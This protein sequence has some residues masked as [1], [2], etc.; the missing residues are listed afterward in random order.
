M[1][2]PPP[3]LSGVRVIDLAEGFAGSYCAQLLGDLGATVIKVE[4]PQGDPARRTGPRYPGA[5]RSATSALFVAF[6]RGKQSVCLDL[7]SDEG[8]E[9]F[10]RLVETADVVVETTTPGK[11]DAL[12][13][14]Y[15]QLSSSN[16]RLVYCGIS[17]YGQQGRRAG[18]RGE[19]INF[20]AMSGVLDLT[21]ELDGPPV[22]PAG[23]QT[24]LAAAMRATIG[25][26]AALSGRERTGKGRSMDVSIYSAALAA[27]TGL[28]NSYLADGYLPERGAVDLA[29]GMVCCQAYPCRDGWVSL[30]ALT[31]DAWERFCRA[32]GREDLI[33]HHEDR[34]NGWAHGELEKLFLR[35]TRAEWSAFAEA[36]DC[37]L[38]PV[39]HL[40]EALSSD[41]AHGAVHEIDQPGAPGVRVFAVPIL[42]GAVQR[43]P[44][45][46]LGEHTT[47]ITASLAR[48]ARDKPLD[49]R[50]VA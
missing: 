25:I 19:D 2:A 32:V 20:A 38:E 23:R 33:S 31:A 17:S 12:G 1:N 40:D 7:D 45:P 10:L 37:C 49:R 3:A 36:A 8:L 9:L 14:G 42:A 50:Q 29:G 5:D 34:S 18:R 47:T 13:I 44:A 6:N 22:Q 21:G 48:R 27:A 43:A 24:E 4:G 41:L 16:P 30:G 46:E 35:R 28:A 15:D 11:L 26:L 39:L